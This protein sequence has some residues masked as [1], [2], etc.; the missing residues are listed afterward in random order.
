MNLQPI[1]TAVFVSNFVAHFL[2]APRLAGERAARAIQC[3]EADTHRLHIPVIEKFPLAGHNI[4]ALD[5][6]HHGRRTTDPAVRS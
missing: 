3:P 2:C 4:A 1:K 5:C 6:F